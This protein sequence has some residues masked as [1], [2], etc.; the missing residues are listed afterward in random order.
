MQLIFRYH[1]SYFLFLSFQN[2]EEWEREGKRK[3]DWS[4]FEVQGPTSWDFY[5]KKCKEQDRAKERKEKEARD[6]QEQG[7]GSS[8]DPFVE[9]FNQLENIDDVI[10][11]YTP[12]YKEDLF[13]YEV[14]EEKVPDLN[15]GGDTF[16]ATAKQ[17]FPHLLK[18]NDSYVNG[19]ILMGATKILSF[20]FLFGVGIYAGLMVP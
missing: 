19:N 20:L 14:V 3:T 2:S 16:N 12:L 15:D 13:E 7:G 5:F 18:V 10:E 4:E 17:L 6:R 11:P 1:L 9:H 8:G